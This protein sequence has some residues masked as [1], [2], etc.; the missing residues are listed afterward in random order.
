VT[1][2]WIHRATLAAK[3]VEMIAGARY[4]RV[5]DAGLHITVADQQHVLPVDNVIISAGQEPNRDL[6]DDLV[7]LGVS[8]HLVGGSNVASE[9][10]AKRAIREATE[11]ANRL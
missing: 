10:D 8:P 11:L 5:D 7:T 4:D 9:L 3:G 2:G 6:F 1:T